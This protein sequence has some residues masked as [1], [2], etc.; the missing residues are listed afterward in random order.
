M[1]T[2]AIDENQINK[3]VLQWGHVQSDVETRL[4]EVRSVAPLKASM[5]PRPIGRG[6]DGQLM[7]GWSDPGASMGPRPIG[8]GNGL[9]GLP[10]AMGLG[11]SMGPRP[12]G[13]GNDC[14]EAGI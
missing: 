11:A 12:I 14:L 5:G 8:R 9:A 6:N 3:R 13:R 1:E 10:Y 4:A 7:E 2:I